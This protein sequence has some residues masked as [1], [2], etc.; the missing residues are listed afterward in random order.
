MEVAM[1]RL[2][3]ILVP[4]DFSYTSAR[5]LDVG[6]ELAEAL[7]AEVVVLH[8]WEPPRFASS[9][10]M[11]IPAELS[12][13]D[14]IERIHTEVQMRAVDFVGGTEHSRDV[15]IQTRVESGIAYTTIVDIAKHESIDLIVMGTHGRSGLTHFFIGSVAERVVRYAD[16]PVLTIRAPN[17][18]ADPDDDLSR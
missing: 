6:I 8:V 17:A 15:S 11:F 9:S 12:E 14:I 16:C 7:G 2:Q 18:E 10:M 4:V 3:R 5:A 13:E 1:L